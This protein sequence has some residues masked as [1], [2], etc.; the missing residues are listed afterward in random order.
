MFT[1]TT[2]D[3]VTH[4]NCAVRPDS[5]ISGIGVRHAYYLQ[6]LFSIFLNIAAQWPSD[7]YLIDVSLLVSS[8]TFIAGTLF[9][10]TIDAVHAILAAHFALMLAEARTPTFLWPVA[11]LTKK[12]GKMA[13]LR[14]EVVEILFRP[15]LVGFNI[16]LWKA[17]RK[18]RN[19]CPNGAGF[20]VFFGHVSPV[21][22]STTASFLAFAFILIMSCWQLIQVIASVGRLWRWYRDKALPQQ[23]VRGRQFP[24]LVWWYLTLKMRGWEEPLLDRKFWWIG[25]CI[26]RL[27]Q[28]FVVGYVIITVEWML[29]VNGIQTSENQWEFGQIAAMANLLYMGAVVSYRIL[30]AFVLSVS[31]SPLIKF[32]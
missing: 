2:T 1:T 30:R 7:I 18:L 26:T 16:V 14:M 8:I 22:V 27:A 4:I 29:I 9:S 19:S 31:S 24:A 20:W 5:D 28:L 15:V 11:A 17:L 21:G 23:V 10:P 13:S 6:A 3:G 12:G 32:R 25:F